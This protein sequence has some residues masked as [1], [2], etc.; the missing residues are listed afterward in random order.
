MIREDLLREFPIK[1]LKAVDGMAV[2]AGV[3]EEAHDYHRQR[4][5]FHALLN[6][7]PG[8]VTGLEVIA[9]DPP[10][11]SVYIL[12]GI[13]VDPLGQTIVLP[14]P[15][16]YDVG[17][18]QGLLYLLLT[19][20][21]SNPTAEDD[22]EEGALYVHGQ[23]G[24]EAGLGLPDTP[25]VELAR[26]RRQSRES[27][28]MDAQDAAHPGPNKI[29]LRFRQ[30]IGA[31]PQEVVSLAVVYAGGKNAGGKTDER[32]ERGARYL[33]RTLGHS[34]RRRAWV[35]DDVPLAPG[36]EVYTLVYLVGREAFQLSRD[37]MNALY[38]YLQEGGT[39]FIESCR[40]GTETGDPAADASFADLLGSLGLQLEA[41]PPGHSL[42][43]EPS[44][45]AVPPPGFET[46]G[47]PGVSIGEGV[48]F[49]THDYGCLWQGE[50]RSG[51]ASREEIRA[52]LEWGGNLVTYAMER[53]RG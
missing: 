25:W 3:W 15:M 42:L 13:A 26:I 30:E 46:E 41:L 48:I 36:L 23:F 8:I 34:D 4:Q 44:L 6:H 9:S 1:R 16:V 43:L 12:P 29:D 52:A 21:E 40:Q 35:D 39:V 32:H 2:T 45:F 51:A 17:T 24:I 49:S 19:Y 28:I 38:A 47:A 10:D 11:S 37:E 50:R 5:R 14:E 33:A 18:T 53:R 27:P 22:R 7:G 31:A 20:G